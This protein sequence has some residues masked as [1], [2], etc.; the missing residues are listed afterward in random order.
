MSKKKVL[1]ILLL[2]PLFIFFT[3]EEKDGHSSLV[4][5]LGKVINFLILFGGLAYLLHR[6]ILNFFE[7]R[8]TQ[9]Q[10]SLEEAQQSRREAEE[11]L[12]EVKIRM[13]NL[14]REILRIREEAS[15]AGRREKERIERLAQTEAERIKRLA[16][17]EME[18]ILRSGIRELKVYAARKAIQLAR[19]RIKAR[20]TEERHFALIDKS[21]ERI[22]NFYEKTHSG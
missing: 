22:E 6:P 16:R 10:K 15:I 18:L 14:E 11:K 13:E 3:A 1:S 8:S 20:M 2:L 12:S 17:Q 9:V 7:Q 21:I 19:E 4:D 5:F